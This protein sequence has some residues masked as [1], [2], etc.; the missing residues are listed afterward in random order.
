MKN[1]LKFFALALFALGA[2]QKAAAV[3]VT[4][5]SS[6]MSIGYM[7]VFDTANN[8][9]WG[10]G[11]G[12]NDLRASYSG[13]LLTVQPNTNCWAPGDAYWVAG[14]VGQK[15]ME[16]N[17]FAENADSATVGLL[18]F[19]GQTVSNTLAAGYSAVAFIKAINP[20]NGWSMDVFQSAALI[21]GQAFS[22]SYDF[23][24]VNGL[25]VQYGIMTRGLVSD[26][27]VDN[28]SAVVTVPEPSSAALMG[29]GLA[30]L[31]AF[32]LRRKV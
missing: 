19:S 3:N 31:L 11:W 17:I 13:S 5:D 9:Q 24:G 27:N 4:I 8:Y 32:R 10:S 30:G 6:A 1:Y 15:I 2:V 23:T 22:V 20:G 12:I 21:G 7:N 29:L 28:G 18:N 26:P 25:I 16:A 14:G